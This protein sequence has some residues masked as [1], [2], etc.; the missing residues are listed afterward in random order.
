MNRA[1]LASCL[2]LIALF[3]AS[4]R[5]SA[6]GGFS[7][8]AFNAVV[9]R[10]VDSKGLVDYKGIIADP[11]GLDGYLAAVGADSPTS[12]PALFPTKND[13]L[14]YYINAYNAMAIKGVATRPGIKTVDSVKL[15]F[16]ALSK[17]AM[18]KDKISLYTLEN[19][20]V[21]KQFSD[22]R[23]HFALNC[24]SGGCPRLPNEAFD[25]ARLD[26]QLD[27]YTREFCTNPKKVY[28]DAAG[29]HIS[30][31]FEWYAKDFAAAGGAVAFI[32]KYGGTIPTTAKVQFIPYDW[33]LSAQAGKNP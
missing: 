5:A 16:F 15:D 11:S 22:P 12:N 7:H 25:S 19:D 29:A 1:L 23:A 17:F 31:I 4:P 24:Q 20:I 32:N 30:Q 10:Y 21:R 33:T 26:A 6:S 14:A 3:F 9:A 13:K 27:A 2:A 8:A 28:V 18:G